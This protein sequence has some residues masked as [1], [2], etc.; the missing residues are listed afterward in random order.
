MRVLQPAGK[1]DKPARQPQPQPH[2]CS[3]RLLSSL[4]FAAT[5]KAVLLC[6]SLALPATDSVAQL[7]ASEKQY[8]FASKPL[9]PVELKQPFPQAKAAFDKTRELILAN[10]YSDTITEE[11]LYHAATLGMLRHISPPEDPTRAKLWSAGNYS[12]V[13]NK[14][15]GVRTS[16]GIR[17]T[18]S[19]HDGALT[20]TEVIPGSP[21]DGRL[22]PYDRIMRVGGQA[23]QGR[24]VKAIQTSLGGAP[25]EV[26]RLTVVRDITVREIE[27]ELTTFTVAE[28]TS[29]L[30]T[31]GLGYLRVKRMTKGMSNHVREAI[32]AL[33]N[34]GATS[35]VLDLRGNTG[36]VFAEGL[37]VAE[38]FVGKG[39]PLLHTLRHGAKLASYKAGKD[40]PFAGSM[41]VLV[42][43]ST[44]SAAEI[45]VAALHQRPGTVIIGK[46]T[47]GK[48]ILEQTF[49]LDN[50]Y[51]V[52]FIVGAL[53]GPKGRAWQGK[54]IKPGIATSKSTLPKQHTQVEVSTWLAKDAALRAA[55]HY[56]KAATRDAG[57]ETTPPDGRSKQGS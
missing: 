40:Q 25:G 22:Q 30:L 21:A 27:I 45:V 18:F 50:D 9:F 29:R 42:D 51:R 37:R 11:A 39:A 6:L 13:S 4:R 43:K 56:L 2:K 57:S 31:D 17:S 53:Y 33:N 12:S 38:L 7:Q 36:G 46:K 16:L 3:R 35:L 34:E 49:T 15:K 54:G 24:N 10:Y 47:F 23:L 55:Y 52:K 5:G 41:A 20:V 8:E 48:G 19:K 44:A 1:A 28:H 32:D 26:V 14:L